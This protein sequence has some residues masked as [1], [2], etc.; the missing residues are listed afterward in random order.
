MK[1]FFAGIAHSRRLKKD[2]SELRGVLAISVSP[3]SVDQEDML[4][5]IEVYSR[6]GWK[7]YSVTFF[8]HSRNDDTEF[9]RITLGGRVLAKRDWKFHAAWQF[10]KPWV[11]RIVDQFFGNDKN[12]VLESD[13]VLHL[14]DHV[15][16]LLYRS[17]CIHRA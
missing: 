4:N 16:R 9:F 12:N 14:E 13:A 15:E 10:P 11:D 17:D 3:H 5:R 2:L 1:N 7:K 6:T 8:P